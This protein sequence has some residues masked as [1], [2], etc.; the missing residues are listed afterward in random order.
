LLVYKENPEYIKTFP[1]VMYAIRPIDGTT[2]WGMGRW[3]D[4]Y[5]YYIKYDGEYG[6][7]MHYKRL[8]EESNKNIEEF[9]K[10]LIV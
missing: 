10:K 2:R 4:E 3:S 1:Y 8:F 6:K 9:Y 5:N 7:A